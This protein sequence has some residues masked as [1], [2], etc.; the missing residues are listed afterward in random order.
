MKSLKK[1]WLQIGLLMLLSIVLVLFVYKSTEINQQNYAENL[2][3]KL[4]QGDASSL[5]CKS[6]IEKFNID[7]PLN[8]SNSYES[9]YNYKKKR[10]V[11]YETQNF[12][13]DEKGLI[14]GH[15]DKIFDL[16]TGDILVSCTINYKPTKVRDRARA[17]AS[18]TC[19][20]A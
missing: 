8:G 7:N 9:F 19:R 6:L 17:Y 15:T 16:V 3:N 2:W 14:T 12:D 18:E 5:Q 13:K 4:S 11:G 1:N 20:E 10:C